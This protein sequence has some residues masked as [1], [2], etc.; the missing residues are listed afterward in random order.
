MAEVVAPIPTNFRVT[1]KITIPTNFRVTSK[2]T[3]R[4]TIS[5]GIQA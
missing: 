4:G 2:I 5:S 3:I 1:S